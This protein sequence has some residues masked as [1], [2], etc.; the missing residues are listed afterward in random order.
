MAKMSYSEYLNTQHESYFDCENNAVYMS[1]F[2]ITG[3]FILFDDGNHVVM[4]C[5]G[6]PMAF[7][8]KGA[9]EKHIEYLKFIE[10]Q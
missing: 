7:S 8:T 9:C 1:A 4:R 2:G 6:V 10:K 3:W 5:E